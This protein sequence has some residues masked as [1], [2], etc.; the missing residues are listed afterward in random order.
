MITKSIIEDMK[1]SLRNVEE[2]GIV[3][4]QPIESFV[5]DNLQCRVVNINSVKFEFMWYDD[6][7]FLEYASES[8]AA[9]KTLISEMK[10]CIE[11]EM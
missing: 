2:N 7:G 5:D 6:V 9:K 4:I 3:F 11:M 8:E 1:K 10:R